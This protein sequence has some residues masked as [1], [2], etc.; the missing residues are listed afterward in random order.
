MSKLKQ[1]PFCGGSPYTDSATLRV[2]GKRTGHD[3][4]VA[5]SN[6]EVSSPGAETVVGAIAAW[7][8]RTLTVEYTSNIEQ[9][10]LHRAYMEAYAAVDI[11][12]AMSETGARICFGVSEDPELV[13]GPIILPNGESVPCS[14]SFHYPNWSFYF[15]VDRQTFSGV[16]PLHEVPDGLIDAV[17][18][19]AL[20]V[21]S[22]EESNDA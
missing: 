17:K 11:M 3:W 21:S 20:K 19:L 18:L 10:T 14:A 8:N 4:A 6:C 12:D 1:C 5:C 16:L 2:F 22:D 13:L 9:E 7:N 15:T